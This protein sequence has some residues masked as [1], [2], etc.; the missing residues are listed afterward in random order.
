MHLAK[1]A[2]PVSCGALILL[3]GLIPLLHD[4]RGGIIT[5]LLCVSHAMLDE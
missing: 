1:A 5:D 2:G 4:F 3:F